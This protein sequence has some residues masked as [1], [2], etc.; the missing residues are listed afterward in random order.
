MRRWC[1]LLILALLTTASIG[2]PVSATPVDA[3]NCISST[4]SVETDYADVTAVVEQ[5]PNRS[6]VVQIKYNRLSSDDRLKIRLPSDVRIV[7]T[8]GF[9]RDTEAATVEYTGG[10]QAI[11]E[12]KVGIQSEET[13]YA[14]GSNWLFAPTPTHIGIGVDLQLEPNGVVGNEFLYIGNYTQYS[15]TDGCHKVSI[16]SSSA[17]DVP[18]DPETITHA[19]DYAAKNLDIGHKLPR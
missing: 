11:L 2:Q 10:D 12:Y 14:N 5:S 1:L 19:L 15:T 6:D 18:T 13:Q 7:R 4:A 17:G 8:T 9:S 16:V 3:G